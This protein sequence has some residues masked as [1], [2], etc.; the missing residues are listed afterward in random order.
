MSKYLD[1]KTLLF[2]SI[3]LN[4]G[5][6][7]VYF[8]FHIFRGVALYSD[9]KYRE[10]EEKYPYISKRILRDLP[11]DILLNFLDLRKE[12][13]S[14]TKPYGDSFGF[15]F[16]YLPTGTTIGV[17]EKNEFFAASLFK[18]PVTMAYYKFLER[19]NSI[20]DLDK[21]LTVESDDVDTQWGS[22]W[23]L[24]PGSKIKMSEVIRLTLEE[25]DNTAARMIA[26]R[27]QDQDFSDVY[28]GLD[29]DLK[30]ASGGAVLTAK[31]YTSILK[32]LYFSS[33]LNRDNS[34][35]I[36]DYLSKSNFN[37]QLVAGVPKDI[38]VAH[39]IGE[40]VDENG[41]TAYMDCGI[42]YVPRRPYSL[43]MIS[44]SDE[45]T[46]AERMSDLSRSVYQYV[47]T[48]K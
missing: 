25:S 28:Q 1:K 21:E 26:E 22:L 47:A 4:I 11:Q 32:A 39:K 40:Y 42:V 12:L 44:V 37:D 29:I 48:K 24:G 41:K 16:E 30:T 2:L 23:K 5:F 18:V 35:Q 8:Y 38:K 6:L 10:L 14:Q 20:E 9:F 33:V 17:N 13:R 7:V 15:F 31:N 36:L 19:T 45:K 3:L 27:V 46:A 34:N 43:C